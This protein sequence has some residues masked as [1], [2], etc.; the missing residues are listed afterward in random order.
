ML[1]ILP[2]VEPFCRSDKC[3]RQADVVPIVEKGVKLPVISF[4]H[5][6]VFAKTQ[7]NCECIK[8][9]TSSN[10]YYSQPEIIVRASRFNKSRPKVVPPIV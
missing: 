10:K 4:I 3:D 8:L 1:F 5:K 2:L 7:I 9:E 6:M